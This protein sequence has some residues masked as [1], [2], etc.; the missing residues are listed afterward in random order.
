MFLCRPCFLSRAVS[1]VLHV[2]SAMIA[3]RL[4]S[5]NLE[6]QGACRYAS[7][8]TIPCIRKMHLPPRGVG[9]FR[10]FSSPAIRASDKPW[11]FVGGECDATSRGLSVSRIRR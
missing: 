8:A 11:A 10:L 3:S 9:T 7:R 2:Q 5:S 6:P 4:S 1:S